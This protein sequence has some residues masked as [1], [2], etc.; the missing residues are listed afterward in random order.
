MLL[1]A[2]FLSLILV[3]VYVG[4]VMTLFLFVVMMLNVTAES[5]RR[6]FG[7]WFPVTLFCSVLFVMLMLFFLYMRNAN[8]LL[9]DSQWLDALNQ[10]SNTKALGILLF[11]RY[12]FEFELAG[13]LLLAAMIAAIALAYRGRKS[14]KSQDISKQVYTRREDCVK[15][16][17]MK[18][19]RPSSQRI[20]PSEG[21]TS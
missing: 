6:L 19:A 1:H 15:L 9:P 4:A 17:S 14:R 5:R 10:H 21:K 20:P 16:V 8:H 12:L 3:L 7:K 11:T 13:M 18:P 2:E